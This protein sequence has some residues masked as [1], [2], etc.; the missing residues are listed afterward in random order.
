MRNPLATVLAWLA[1]TPCAMAAANPWNGTWKLDTSRPEPQ[2]GADD[3]R[4]TVSPDGALRWEIPSL[5]EDNHG[6]LDGRPMA[7][8]R[9]G[10]KPGMTISVSAE[11]PRVWHYTVAL[12]GAYRGEG[13]M[14]LAQDGR[15]WTDMVLDHGKPV[16]RLTLVY[17]RQ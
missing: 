6:R 1:V 3:Y 10:G 12:N 17:V 4:F 8:N 9:P 16:E 15:S 5:R 11:G 7:I 13:R 14:S 2:G